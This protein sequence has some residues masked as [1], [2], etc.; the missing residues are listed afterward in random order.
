MRIKT[1]LFITL[2]SFTLLI[3]SC[4]NKKT[5]T[6]VIDTWENGNPRKT[7]EYIIED[8]GKKTVY[9][10]TSYHLNEQKFIE[11]T[12]DTKQERNGK[13]TSWFDDGKKNSQGTYV[14]GELD[15]KYTVWH[16]NGNIHYTGQYKKGKQ[17][18]KWTFYN[19]NGKLL[20]EIEY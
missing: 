16:P 19:D 5:E 13:W 11:G 2:L 17:I 15:G 7:I 14:N 12:Y 20:K 18:G 3:I 9:K 10:E 1:N 4:Q 6:V 8:D